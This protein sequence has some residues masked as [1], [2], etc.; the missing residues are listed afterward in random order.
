MIDRPTI[1]LIMILW[2]IRHVHKITIILTHCLIDTYHCPWSSRINFLRN[3]LNILIWRLV[4]KR[5]KSF[6]PWKFNHYADHFLR[7][8]L[9]F[10]SISKYLTN[11]RYLKI[12]LNNFR[13]IFDRSMKEPVKWWTFHSSTNTLQV[14]LTSGQHEILIT[15]ADK[16]WIRAE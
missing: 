16:T 8:I 4:H 10:T 12:V 5:A 6:G 3:Y 2:F 14:Y 13:K 1:N 15:G 11:T 7:N 9:H